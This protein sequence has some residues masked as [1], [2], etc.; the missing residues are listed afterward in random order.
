M[1]VNRFLKCFWGEVDRNRCTGRTTAIALKTIAEAIR[2]Y[3][4]EIPVIDHI[5]KPRCHEY[6]FNTIRSLISQLNLKGFTLNHRT[7]TIRCD[8]FVEEDDV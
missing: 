3:G 7:M 1:L 4:H 2:R 8:I 6:L 5:D